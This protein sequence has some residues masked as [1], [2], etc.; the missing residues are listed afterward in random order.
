MNKVF[1]ID[2]LKKNIFSYLRKKPQLICHMCKKVLIWDKEV[3][4]YIIITANDC[5]NKYHQCLNCYYGAQTR[6]FFL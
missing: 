3:N 5:K 6:D 2:D 1:E 4:P